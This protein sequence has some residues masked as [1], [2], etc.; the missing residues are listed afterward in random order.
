EAI[1]SQH[2]YLTSSRS[3]VTAIALRLFCND[4]GSVVIG[5]FLESL[6]HLAARQEDY[7]LLPAQSQPTVMN[8][9]GASAAGKS[10]MRPL[11]KQLA[12]RLGIAWSDFALISPD[13]WRKYLLDY[14]SLG[15]ARR[16]AGTLTGSEV[17]IVDQKLDRHMAYKSK[18]GR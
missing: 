3:L 6:V 14:A 12:Q 5:E 2:G 7:R 18:V 8:V 1:F 4:Y 10:S 15:A 13:I 9:K 16:Y 17:A 11:Q